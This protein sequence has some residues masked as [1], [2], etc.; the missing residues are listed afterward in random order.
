MRAIA[1]LLTCTA[2]SC[3][4]SARSAV[5]CLQLG[6]LAQAELKVCRI[7]QVSV[8][9]FVCPTLLQ[10]VRLVTQTR[11][12]QTNSAVSWTSGSVTA[13]KPESSAS[14]FSKCHSVRGLEIQTGIPVAETCARQSLASSGG[15][16]VPPVPPR[17]A[18]TSLLK[19]DLPAIWSSIAQTSH[20][21]RECKAQ[22]PTCKP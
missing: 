4:G 17:P 10:K 16:R 20:C 1:A 11:K 5:C 22:H 13:Y 12:L 7:H 18:A 3:W 15:L 19:H 8:L 21:S 6:A 14:L 9:P 2:R